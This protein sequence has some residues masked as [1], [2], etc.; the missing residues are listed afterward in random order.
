MQISGCTVSFHRHKNSADR[1]LVSNQFRVDLSP[2]STAPLTPILSTP[3][4]NENHTQASTLSG[5]QATTHSGLHV[6]TPSLN[7]STDL[8]NFAT[9][10]SHPIP[11]P[12][13]K[14]KPKDLNRVSTPVSARYNTAGVVFPYHR[15]PSPRNRRS[16][17][18]STTH[19]FS[20]DSD[21]C[22]EQ[23]GYKLSSSSHSNRS[24]FIFN[25][26]ADQFGTRYTPTSPLSPKIPTTHAGLPSQS[27]RTRTGHG[28]QNSRNLHMTLPRYHPANFQHNDSVATPS[29]PVH[30]P[31]I[32]I[33]RVTQPLQLESPRLMR[34]KQKEFLDRA[35]MTSKIAASSMGVK[36]D[37]PRLDPLGSPKGQVTPLALE[38]AGDYFQVSSSGKHSPAASPGARS[39][40]SDD[41]SGKEESVNKKPR[42]TDV[43]Q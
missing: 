6:S 25:M 27:S 37:A 41:S 15:S 3:N 5:Y 43:Y 33:N 30:S 42:T 10:T 8:L 13:T 26:H 4:A 23:L 31:A 40:R 34:E 38:E 20:P 35:R 18:T 29:S 11:I 36:P 12:T 16:S 22:Q 2:L 17:D 24:I 21:I 7:T 32:T 1:L 39:A 28:R 19:S 14:L 9:S